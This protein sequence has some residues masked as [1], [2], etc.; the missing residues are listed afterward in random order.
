MLRK[1]F[2]WSFIFIFNSDQY[3]HLE[4]KHKALRTAVTML[5]NKNKCVPDITWGPDC[6]SSNPLIRW[7]VFHL[8]IPTDFSNNVSPDSLS[9]TADQIIP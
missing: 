4:E 7:R 9:G 5:H 8:S 1:C 3:Q 2:H 6:E